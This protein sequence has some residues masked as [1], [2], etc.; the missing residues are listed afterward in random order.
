[1]YKLKTT[2][3]FDSAHFLKGYEGK[4]S[5]IH[6]HRWKIDVTIKSENLTES[7]CKK[8]MVIDFSDFKKD[9]QL[10]ADKF[11]HTLIY[12]DG[13]LGEKLLSALE[14]ENF[15][16]VCLKFRPTAENLARYFFEEIKKMQYDVENVTVYETAKNCAQYEED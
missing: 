2:V 8:G 16:M 3:Y 14:E 1:M 12:E 7:G 11:D 6:G 5:N 10:L 9:M 13:S 15:K 4:C